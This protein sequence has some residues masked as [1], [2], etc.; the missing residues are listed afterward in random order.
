[1]AECS[2][3]SGS[4]MVFPFP[5]ESRE[6]KRNVPERTMVE[7]GAAMIN[8]FLNSKKEPKHLNVSALYLL[9]IFILFR[10]S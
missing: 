9:T 2:D 6:T 3:L 1:M 7:A 8:T 4:S 5:M 10:L